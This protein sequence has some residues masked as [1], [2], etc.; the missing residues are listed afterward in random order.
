MSDAFF[1]DL[2]MPQPAYFLGI[3]SGSHAEQTARIIIE[4]E[5]VCLDFKPDM[6]IVVGDVNS[7]IACSLTAAK[8]G[9]MT[10]HVEAGLRSFDRSMP[11]ELNR[12]ATDSICDYF[13]V[14]EDSAIEHLKTSGTDSEKIFFVGNTMID[15]LVYAMDKSLNSKI[16]EEL[17]LQPKMYALVTMHRP[18]NV[19][20]E[21]NLKELLDVLIH[22]SMSKVVVFPL[23]PR[24]RKNIET[25]G[26]SEILSN[27]RIRLIDPQGYINFLALMKDADFVLTDSGGIQE[28]TTYLNIP[29]LTARTSTE[30][31]STILYGSN[32]LINPDK[33]SLI[34]AIDYQINNPKRATRIPPLWDG[35]AAKR[36][37]NVLIHKVFA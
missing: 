18:S 6:V 36:I 21:N 10:A 34:K 12:I 1:N 32:R 25:Y 24:T 2:D 16:L 29:C 31:P 30:R 37:V 23:H 28:E 3:G 26:M 8:L 14:T 7:T 5:K 17:G 11:E 9:V 4:F 15:S 20:N 22:L 33:E 27:H 13:F 19:D 35:G